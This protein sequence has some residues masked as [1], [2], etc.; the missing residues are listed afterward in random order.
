MASDRDAEF[1]AFVHDVSPRLLTAGWMLTGDPTSA[2]AL[3]REALERVYLRWRRIKPDARPA[4]ARRVLARRH[5]DLWRRR[6]REGLAD[7]L[8]E[9]GDERESR[10]VELIRSLQ[11]L[12]P[13]EREVVVLAH[14]LDQSDQE[15][16]DALRVSLGQV[17][18]SG[19]QGLAQMGALLGGSSGG[20]TSE[21]AVLEAMDRAAADPPLMHVGAES[22]LSGG[23]ASRRRRRTAAAGMAL[24]AVAVA[25]LLSLVSG[26]DSETMTQEDAPLEAILWDD[27]VDFSAPFDETGIASANFMGAQIE[28]APGEDH[29]TLRVRSGDGRQEVERVDADLPGQVELFRSGDS[30]LLVTPQ[31]YSGEPTL[32]LA[33]HLFSYDRRSAT[34]GDTAVH[35][36][37]V[38][39]VVEPDDVL[40]V[41]WVSGEQM[42]ASSGTEILSAAISAGGFETRVAIVP[43]RGVWAQLRRPVAGLVPIGE[44]DTGS[45]RTDG[46]V[47]VLPPGAHDVEVYV[48]ADVW[49]E[50][51][52]YD[53]EALQIPL[54]L[55][56]VGDYTVGAAAL[57]EF[58]FDQ[59]VV[60]MLAVGVTW[61]DESGDLQPDLGPVP[62]TAGG[63]RL[64]ERAVQVRFDAIDEEVI[65]DPRSPGVAM[66]SRPGGSWVMVST[67][68]EEMEEEAAGLA[69]PV[70][71]T[72]EG[73]QLLLG[74]SQSGRVEGVR[75][76]LAWVAV[77]V[78]D[79]PIE[80]GIVAGEPLPTVLFSG[81]RGP[82]W[83]QGTA[84]E[85]FEVDGT[86]LAWAVKDNLDLW[87]VQCLGPTS[88]GPS[89]PVVGE[90]DSA[91]LRLAVCEDA[92]GPQESGYVVTVLPDDVAR[93]AAIVW[94]AD[95]AS[96]GSVEVGESHIVDIGRGQSLWVVR[97]WTEGQPIY[98]L[99]ADIAG[100]DLDG[101]GVADLPFSDEP[102]P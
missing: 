3:V 32:Q 37:E 9:Q 30:S 70:I 38:E 74:R 35:V 22:I 16:A 19:S 97:I 17:Q 10:H 45:D 52:A 25:T 46:V 14:Y 43:E 71:D 68:P 59:E 54:T 29:F 90:M 84:P 87:A 33:A 4:Y 78:G 99:N 80:Q 81:P 101:D 48:S 7:L 27:T 47:A 92:A 55:Q 5:T 44:V 57:S 83:S 26:P 51:G 23:R 20:V 93:R 64:S 8:P 11:T 63:N 36:W 40:D 67:L 82:W 85:V 77:S 56:T 21:Q 95:G 53:Q 75:E 66:A 18:S 41:Y 86:E 98:E 102:S 100:L 31:E 42:V 62:L 88:A 73:V 50:N 65:I 28:R 76:R 96:Q 49:A 72:E 13:R 69:V 1:V 24:A 89:F 58:D 6:R 12:S 60:Q 91:S 61:V 34:D 94:N 2:E 15:T 79:G 39:G